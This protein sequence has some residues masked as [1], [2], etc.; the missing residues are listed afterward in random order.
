MPAGIFTDPEIGTVGL[1]EHEAAKEGRKVRVG[2]FPF[3]ALGKAL[4]I[5]QTEGWVKLVADEKTDLLLG[6][7]IVGHGAADLTAEIALAIE[8]GA[9]AAD[10]GLTVHAHPTMPESL[11]EAAEAVHKKAIH[12]LNA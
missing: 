9:T 8:M 4:A 12:I 2:K 5:G 1:Q 7:T 11:M 6:A 10:V 3:T